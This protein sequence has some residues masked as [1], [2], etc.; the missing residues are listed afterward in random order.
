MKFDRPATDNP[1]D[2][3]RVVGLPLDRID[4]PAKVSGAAKY[5]YEHN[6][7]APGAAYG[8]IVGATVGK[9]R[10]AALDTREAE[11]ADGVLAVV[12]HRNAGS[13][14]KAARN[15]A[16][17]LG[18]PEI[19]HYD[20]A[21]ALVVAETLEQARDAAKLVRVRYAA[22]KGRFD[23]AAEKDKATPPPPILDRLP[24][25]TKVGDF[26]AAFANAAVKIDQTYT[27]PDQ[28]HMPMEPFA[29]TAAWSGGKLTVWTS[30]Q[31]VNWGVQ[32]L[33]RTLN[34]KAEDIHL[35]SP[36]VGGGFGSKLWVRAEA[37]L[38]ALGA[39]AT[40]RPVKVAIA[41][42]QMPN[43]S[44]HRPA[45]IQRIRLGAD[46]EGKIDAIAH[47]V[48]TG[49]LPKGKP[50]AA[51]LQTRL[52]Y[53]AQNRITTHRL[54]V[55][56]LPEG[57]AM[58]A[59]GEAVGMLALEVAI[60][61]LAEK[62]AIDPIELRI[63]NDVQHDPEKGPERPFSTRKLTE[64]LREGAARFGWAKRKA[65]PGEVRE[66]RW[67]L[68]M[69][70]AAAFR[71]NPVVKS[72]A[73]VAVDRF[74][75]VTVSTDMT[76]IGT[77][78]YTIIGQ[79]AAEML[80]VPIESVVVKLGD[81][82]APVS[83]GS[84]GQFG[85]NSS[86][87]G[88]YAACVA[89][90]NTLAQ[91]A[92]FNTDAESLTFED[93]QIKGDGRAVPIGRAAGAQG[94]AAEDVMEFGELQQTFAQAAFGAHFCEVGVDIDTGETRIR[95][96]LGVFAAGRILN[97]KTARS[98]IIG[99]MTMGAGAALM[100]ELVVD[101]RIGFFVNHDYAEYAVPV[102]ADIPAQEVVFLDELDDKSSPMKAK[103][104]G[105]LGICGAGAAVTNAIYNACGVRVRDY[106]LTLDKIIQATSGVPVSL[107][108]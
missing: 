39:K 15:A 86:T 97:P 60:D 5:A 12:T 30:N 46:R 20:Q 75:R 66:G 94:A 73:R 45:T 56:D 92:G 57:N 91:R 105:E 106:P 84:G 83:C 108:Q 59:P 55:L 88:V 13:L 98:Q 76:D 2:R 21:V 69:G 41:R 16:T 6:D 31:M 67:L 62:C 54:A 103:G 70:V 7:A 50:E 96:M 93:G 29:T 1:I 101:K 28:S 9:G 24:A 53:A 65:T 11:A 51:A 81:S 95:R 90:R 58:R 79:T 48:W 40:G 102:H 3:G 35:M 8:W 14:G 61:E 72:A 38:A 19:E 42:P 49:N 63:R 107:R 18:G 74:G 77:G 43:N 78:S 26:E 89:L 80:G 37:L 4:G 10:I 33:A 99:A 34:M 82:T 25:D 87:A 22:G 68:G 85:A 32:D 52:L 23:L 36:Y 64:C 71:N 27:T 44:V 17:L 100:E 104:V 47:D